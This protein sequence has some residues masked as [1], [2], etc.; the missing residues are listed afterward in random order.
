MIVSDG[1]NRVAV[2]CDGDRFH[3]ID[4][5][6]SDMARQ[7]IL[8][9]A[10]WRFLRVRGTR[11]FRDTEGT[12]KWIIEELHRFGVDPQM[13]LDVVPSLDESADE[14]RASVVRRAWETMKEQGWIEGH[15]TDSLADD[16]AD[17][18]HN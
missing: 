9:R 18:L 13:S 12:M 15:V 6:P 2:E 7:A 14:F 17:H 8:E 10:G 4:Q 1:R 5:I 11:F 16:N 3:T